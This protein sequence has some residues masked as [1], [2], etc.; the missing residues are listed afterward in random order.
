MCN[1]TAKTQQEV[2]VLWWNIVSVNSPSVLF[3]FPL[4][5]EGSVPSLVLFSFQTVTALIDLD[6]NI[7]SHSFSFQHI[8]KCIRL[9]HFFSVSLTLHAVPESDPHSHSLKTFVGNCFCA[10]Q[11]AAAAWCAPQLQTTSG[12]FFRPNYSLHLLL[13]HACLF[14]CTGH[15]M[16]S[17][18]CKPSGPQHNGKGKRE[19]LCSL[20]AVLVNCSKNREVNCDTKAPWCSAVVSHHRCKS[21]AAACHLMPLMSAEL[22]GFHLVLCSLFSFL[23]LCTLTFWFLRP[24][25]TLFMW[26]W[27]LFFTTWVGSSFR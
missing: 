1:W 21:V 17:F 20:W 4:S 11:I 6:S 26:W 3:V 5:V 23:R 25:N 2:V 12:F 9:F 18:H 13:L 19:P 14:F 16:W 22:P 8:M 10:S 15:L 24:S 7:W 27:V